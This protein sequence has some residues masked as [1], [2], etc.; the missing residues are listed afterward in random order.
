MQTAGWPGLS[1][2]VHLRIRPFT[3]C[4]ATDD[5]FMADPI[6]SSPTETGAEPFLPA[7]A[8]E[9]SP[10]P[11]PVSEWQTPPH[12]QTPCP[13]LPGKEEDKLGHRRRATN[14]PG[15]GSTRANNCSISNGP[16]PPLSLSLP[17]NYRCTFGPPGPARP[18]PE[19]AR[20]V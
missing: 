11:P 9:W 18:K 19:K 17:R 14:G 2:P 10:T 8:D 1:P 3:R 5:E 4:C 7:V 13:S 6:A 20:I 12:S 15:F 16:L